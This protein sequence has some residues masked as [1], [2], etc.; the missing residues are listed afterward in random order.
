MHGGSDVDG[1]KSAMHG[2]TGVDEVK[3]GQL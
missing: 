1:A 2:G 3:S